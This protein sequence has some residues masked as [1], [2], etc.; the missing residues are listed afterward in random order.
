VTAKVKE[1]WNTHRTHPN[2]RQV[3]PLP[4]VLIDPPT[5]PAVPLPRVH[6]APPVDDCCMVSVVVKNRL[7]ILRRRLLDPNCRLLGIRPC[8][9]GYMCPPARS[10][11]IYLRMKMKSTVTGT[12]PGPGQQASCRRQ[13]L[14]ASTSPNQVLK[15]R[16]QRWQAENYR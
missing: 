12:T 2:A 16:G 1:R 14:R 13:C 10:P 15:S 7:Y 9:R 5:Q 3:V 4:R 6:A 8:A 11:I